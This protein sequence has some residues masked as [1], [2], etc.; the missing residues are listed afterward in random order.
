MDGRIRHELSG[1]G[2]FGEMSLTYGKTEWGWGET[3]R[4][5]YTVDWERGSKWKARKGKDSW[6]DEE[7]LIWNKIEIVI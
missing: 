3:V 5:C 4:E 7:N 1:G 6:Y 2:L